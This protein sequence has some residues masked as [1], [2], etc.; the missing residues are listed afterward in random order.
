MVPFTRSRLVLLALVAPALV[1][2]SRADTPAAP[3]APAA[4][5]LTLTSPAFADGGNIP[6]ART[7]DGQN[8]SPELQWSG[9][10]ANTA[11]YALIVDDPDAPA[12]TFTHWVLFDIP[13]AQTA[14]PQ[15]ETGIGQPGQNGA[16]RPGYTG[17]CPPSGTHRYFF[18]LYALDLPTLGLSA[19][20]SRD[21]VVSAMNGHILAQGQLMGRY[22]R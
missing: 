9:A 13:A 8:D 17:P 5:V 1:A 7:C 11:S 4:A 3:A 14:L 12:G 15:G 18:R 10:P 21:Q 20:A 22:A 19:G 16:G 6:R 2:C